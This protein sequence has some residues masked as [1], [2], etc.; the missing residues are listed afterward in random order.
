MRRKTPATQRADSLAPL[1]GVLD[2]FGVSLDD[3]LEGTGLSGA[4]ILPGRFIAYDA[5]LAILQR[6]ADR[7][8]REDFGLLLG[9]RETLATVGPL[10]LAVRSS[11]TLGE[12]LADFTGFQI[13]NSSGAAT[14]LHRRDDMVF[15]GYG[16]HDPKLTVSPYAHDI[17]LSVMSM[18]LRELTKGAVRAVEFTSMRWKPADPGPWLRLGARVRFG[19]AETG[20]YISVRDMAFPLPSADRAARDEALRKLAAATGTAPAGWEGRTRHALRALIL[21]G[22]SGM[23]E[24]ARHL[25]IEPRTLRRALSREG[26]T[27]DSIRDGVRLAMARELLSMSSLSIADLALTL[28]YATSSA[29]I[30]AFRRW[31][32]QPP[33]AWR[34]DRRSATG[35]RHR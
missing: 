2:D 18:M 14:Y 16:S 27:F 31:T 32:G 30:N 7:T 12:A 8:G 11:A 33:A 25:D 10:A 34:K 4:D 19:E 23:P 22:R 17:V 6:A 1:A 5:Y 35:A 28:D 29:F 15:L 26:T 20:C 13:S 3:V 21:E 24:V 9:S